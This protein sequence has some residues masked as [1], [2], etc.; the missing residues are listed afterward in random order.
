MVN[1]LSSKSAERVADFLAQSNTNWAEIFFSPGRE[2]CYRN[3]EKPPDNT[4][5]NMAAASSTN[6]NPDAWVDEHGDSLY[7]YVIIRVR[8]PEVAEDLV[9][10]TPF[11]G[12]PNALLNSEEARLSELGSI[13]SSAVSMRLM[14][15]A[16]GSTTIVTFF[17]AS[18]QSDP[19]QTVLASIPSLIATCTEN[20]PASD[21]E[22]LCGA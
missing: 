11:V 3:G 21:V 17:F 19:I 2:L 16:V 15:A 1:L 8:C 9:Q 5:A 12:G 6:I 18:I 14:L 22:D 13:A 7:G 4:A 20:L 10:E